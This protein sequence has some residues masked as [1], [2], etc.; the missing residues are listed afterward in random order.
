VPGLRG[1]VRG[2]GGLLGVGG[3]RGVVSELLV[4]SNCPHNMSYQSVY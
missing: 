1:G 4:F 2:R 3:G